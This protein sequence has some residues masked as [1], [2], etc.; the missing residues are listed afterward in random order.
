MP[1]DGALVTVI[2]DVLAHGLAHHTSTDPTDTRGLGAH[3]SNYTMR[4]GRSTHRNVSKPKS[5]SS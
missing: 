5:S 1:Y 4:A 3:R 2:N